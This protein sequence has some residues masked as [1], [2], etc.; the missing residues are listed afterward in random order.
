MNV[1]I[2]GAGAMGSAMARRLRDTGHDVTIW[3]RKS[4]SRDRWE[5]SGVAIADD[6]AS[7]VS[8]AF[9]VI[10]MVTD[11]EAVQAIAERMLDAMPPEAVWV[12]A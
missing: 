12:Q 2:L 8:A 1:T 10:T 7:A 4:N 3:D 11:G 6:E 9:V 5:C